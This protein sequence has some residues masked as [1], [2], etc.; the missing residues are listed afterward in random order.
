MEK[1]EKLK[2]IYWNFIIP[3]KCENIKFSQKKN[4]SVHSEKKTMGRK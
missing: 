2:L 1:L 4:N 3:D